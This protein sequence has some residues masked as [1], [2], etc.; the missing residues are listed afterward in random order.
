MLRV[1]CGQTHDLPVVGFR[2]LPSLVCERRFYSHTW[3]H[4]CPSTSDVEASLG[5]STGRRWKRALW[6][7]FACLLLAGIVGAAV[8][9]LRPKPP[10]IRWRE[11]ALDSGDIVVKVGATG[12]LEPA[13]SVRV[14]A[15]VSGRVAEVLVDHNDPVTRGQVLVRLDLDTFS[16][17][18]KEAQASSRG[19]ATEVTRARA[20][21]AQAQVIA[22]QAEQLSADG[23]I[24]ESEL[25]RAQT[26]LSVAKASVGTTRAQRSLA[27]IRVEQAQDQLDKAVITSPIDGV[28]LGR[29]VEPGNTIVASFQAPEL[30]LLA[31]DLRSMALELDID[32]ADVGQLAVGQQATFTVDAWLGREF[33]ATVA[34]V[35]FSP[36]TTNAVVTYTAELV[37]DNSALLLRPGMTVSADIVT[38]TRRGVLRVSNTA[39]RFAPPADDTS[40]AGFQFGP[41]AQD[42]KRASRAAIWALRDG[43][44]VQ[45]EATLGAS[46]GYF[47]ELVA[48][49]LTEG[50]KV[51]V[52]FAK[53]SEP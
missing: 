22:Q 31:E 8:L 53:D 16:N 32:E 40:G 6:I 23:V 49:D 10:A 39:L 3:R 9:W 46:D 26:D 20:T 4:R 33:T 24:S 29:T 35:Y 12:T 11:V 44:P 41:P 7:S 48:G 13:R 45:L 50:T 21:L 38:A 2:G 42:K 51:L 1:G 27:K 25:L 43:V 17:A 19:A 28:V 30:F 52:G 47:T 15:Q 18:L 14:G 37:L 5:I 36:T 34:K